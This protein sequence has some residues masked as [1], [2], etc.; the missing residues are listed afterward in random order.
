M[1]KAF[2]IR[3]MLPLENC[4]VQDEIKAYF[5]KY[6]PQ[7][8]EKALRSSGNLHNPTLTSLIK[9]FL[10][11]LRATSLYKD[12]NQSLN[13]NNFILEKEI[14]FEKFMIFDSMKPYVFHVDIWLHA[15]Q[16]SR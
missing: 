9:H 1:P 4:K 2:A 8:L 11:A 16:L 14:S 3:I 5:K 6:F 12:L 13:N 7:E 15:K 10:Q